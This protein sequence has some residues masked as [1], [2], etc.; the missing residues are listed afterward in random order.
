MEII[1]N[2]W[3]E[4]TNSI[5]LAF[6]LISSFGY[7]RDNLTSN[8]AVIPIAYYLYVNR[9]DSKFID[10]KNF[11][12]DRNNIKIWLVKA[13]IKRVFSGE[14]D[15][16]LRLLRKII[17]ENSGQFPIEQLIDGFR[18][19]NKTIIFTDE[20]IENLVYSRYGSGHTFSILQVLYPYF[21][22]KNKFH[23]DHIH[24]KSL[25]T[26]RRLSNI[27]VNEEDIEF[28]KENVNNL[29]N[30][31][32]LA[33]QTNIEKNDKEFSIWINEM[34]ENDQSRNDY[35]TKHYIPN[36]DLNILNFKEFIEKRNDILKNELSKRLK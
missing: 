36:V 3:N 1:E 7:D 35:I 29:G 30:L 6:Q 22:F 25:F 11:K 20:D 18:G 33:G 9:L 23:V 13:L 31:Q 19:T 27:G 15:N 21:D 26:N 4:I 24:P 5:V 14:V 28:Y 32:L 10:S 16:V 12:D 2:K 34:F 17:K 8:N